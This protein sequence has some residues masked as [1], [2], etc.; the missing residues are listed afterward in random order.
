MEQLAQT[1]NAST[2]HASDD[3]VVR[4]RL[5]PTPVIE[6]LDV[7]AILRAMFDIRVELTRIRKAIEK[8]NGDGE[9]EEENSS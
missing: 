8:E 3:G 4:V 2:P 1:R 5:R 7:E 6:R 9:E